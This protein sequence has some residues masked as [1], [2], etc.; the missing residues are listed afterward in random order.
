MLVYAPVLVFARVRSKR[1]TKR[2][3]KKCVCVQKRESDILYLTL[4]NSYSRIV[5]QDC[6]VFASLQCLTLV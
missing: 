4:H 5:Y 1:K 2:E 6:L 3:E